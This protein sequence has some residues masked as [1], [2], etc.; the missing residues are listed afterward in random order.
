[1]YHGNTTAYPII[2]PPINQCLLAGVNRNNSN[3]ATA[4]HTNRTIPLAASNPALGGG[5][6]FR[7]SPWHCNSP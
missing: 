5:C 2:T 1:M 3:K 6:V 7:R 4:K